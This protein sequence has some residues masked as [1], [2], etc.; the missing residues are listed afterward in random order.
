MASL[1]RAPGAHPG[2][3]LAGGQDGGV[4]QDVEPHGA[5]RLG[6][7]VSGAV[8]PILQGAAAPPPD[9]GIARPGSK[10]LGPT[11]PGRPCGGR[12][13]H[14]IEGCPGPSWELY[15]LFSLQSLVGRK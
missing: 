8:H 3:V 2:P 13:L 11:T 4:P 1:A 5:P 12:A 10:R 6:A 15:F 9:T 7:A 14:A